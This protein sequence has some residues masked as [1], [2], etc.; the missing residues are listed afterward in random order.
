[1]NA[2]RRMNRL[3]EFNRD[4]ET[5]KKR[6][7]DSTVHRWINEG[8]LEVYKLGRMSFVDQTFDEFVARQA[9]KRDG[10]HR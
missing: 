10:E 8:R 3:N 4:P 1:M 2:P 7:A 9:T 5:G 6:V